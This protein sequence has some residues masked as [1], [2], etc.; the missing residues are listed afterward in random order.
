MRKG[1]TTGGNLRDS[2]RLAESLGCSVVKPRN[3]GG[4]YVV[5]HPGVRRKVRLNGRRKDT[6][7]SL[8]SLLRHIEG[9][10]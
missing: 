2:L 6:P 3:N 4:E 1:I 10:G 5:S 7:R 8:T 9:L